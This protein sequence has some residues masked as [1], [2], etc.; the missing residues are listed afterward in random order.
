MAKHRLAT[1]RGVVFVNTTVKNGLKAFA[2]SW[3]MVMGHKAGE[4]S[5]EA[6]TEQYLVRMQRSQ[7]EA[8]EHWDALAYG[9]EIALA[10]FC[11]AG[12]FCHRYLLLKLLTQWCEKRGVSVEHMGELA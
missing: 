5:D 11:R 9:G 4:L 12:N 1:Q 6:Y 7:D 8:P 10:C 2:P 3:E